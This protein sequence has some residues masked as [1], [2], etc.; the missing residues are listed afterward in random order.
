[1][2]RTRL[3]ELRGLVFLASAVSAA[4]GDGSAPSK[5]GPTYLDRD[6]LLDPQTCAN[7][8]PNQYAQWANSMHAYASDDPL[9]VAM[10]ARGQREAQIGDFCVK[11]HAPMAVR[12]GATTDGLNL[13]DVPAKLKGV[14]CFF[15]HTVNEVT[16]S[17]DDPLTLATDDTMR[18]EYTDPVANT[19]HAST[20]SNLH[21][22]DQLAS[23]TL[24]GA[25]HDIVNGHGAHIERT[26][27]E[28]KDTVFSQPAV[29]DTCGQC[30]MNESTNLEPAADA[31]G[32]FARRTHDHTF[33]GV[34]VPLTGASDDLKT[35]VQS[36]L[37]TSL[38]SAVCVRGAGAVTD[39]RVILDNVAAGHSFPSGA[40]QDRRAWVEV[41]A[42]SGQDQIYSSGDV[43]DGTSVTELDDPDV[44]SI[45]DCLLDENGAPT[46]MFWDAASYETNLLPGQAT[47]DQTDPRFYQSHVLQKYPRDPNGF[48]SAYPDRVTVSLKLA[49]FGLDVFDDLV[50]SGDLVDTDTYTVSELRDALAAYTL[51][52]ELDWTPD[53]AAQSFVADGLPMSCKSDTA[54]NFMADTV[55]ATN[56]TICV[57]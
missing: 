40:A 43:P 38:Q 14:T 33:P 46:H 6:T 42:Y 49:P 3:L 26:F 32:V 28:W 13:A 41:A 8:H 51:G 29:G 25:C 35:A 57:P 2:K 56:H 54:L 12:T 31:P 18:G 10:N 19:A 30:H 17:H 23:A 9:F 44:W 1:M 20:G 48:L 50:A 24:C 52:N 55:P 27:A 21:D 22:R 7:C 15:C 36:F 39:V 5:P 34:D 45:R 16:G 11:C 4:C 53:T 47:F 37:D